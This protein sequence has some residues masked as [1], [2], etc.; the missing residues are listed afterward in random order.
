[1]TPG[2]HG[3]VLES[4]DDR[5]G[6]VAAMRALCDQAVRARMRGNCLALRPKLAYGT[7]LDALLEIYARRGNM[8][9]ET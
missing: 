2:E 1:M 6:L 7:H 3:F 8:K 9:H 4:A 5:E